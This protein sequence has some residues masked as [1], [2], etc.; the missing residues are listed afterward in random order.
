MNTMTNE[1]LAAELAAPTNAFP[2][3]NAA[4]AVLRDRI[5]KINNEV[6]RQIRAGKPVF[7]TELVQQDRANYLANHYA[8][9]LKALDELVAAA[10]EACH[11]NGADVTRLRQALHSFGGA[12]PA[13]EVQEL[14]MVNSNVQLLG[15][16]YSHLPTAE[17]RAREC[18]GWITKWRKVG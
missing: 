17:R 15:G 6:Q 3:L 1:Q 4:A 2:A 12:A 14:W 8:S 11:T 5:R 18:A 9:A 13:Q 7:E 16:L 10:N